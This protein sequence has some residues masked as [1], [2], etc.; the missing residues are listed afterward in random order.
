MVKN[1]K[2]ES[3]LDHMSCS[4]I[5]L[6]VQLETRTTGLVWGGYTAATIGDTFVAKTTL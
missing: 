1:K 6:Q 4:S 3:Q 5:H 2:L